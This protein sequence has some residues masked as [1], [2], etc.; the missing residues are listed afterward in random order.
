MNKVKR[1]IYSLFVRANLLKATDT[2]G[3]FSKTG[4]DGDFTKRNSE[5]YLIIVFVT[6][7]TFLLQN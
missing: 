6:I 2:I 3:H 5:A 7:L 1:L 4:T